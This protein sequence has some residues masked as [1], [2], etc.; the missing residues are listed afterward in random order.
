MFT[1][2]ENG[3]TNTGPNSLACLETCSG[4]KKSCILSKQAA[5]RNSRALL[6]TDTARFET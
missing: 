6:C 4:S 3:Y 2:V 5:E 1:E